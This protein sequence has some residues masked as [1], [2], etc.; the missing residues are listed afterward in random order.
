MKKLL[1]AAAI[2]CAA[3][4]SQAAVCNWSMSNVTAYPGAE[5]AAAGWK[6]YLISASE[7]DAFSALSGDKV[8]GWLAKQTPIDTTETVAGGRG[9]IN[10]GGT[11]GDNYGVGATES[12]FIVLFNNASAA[13]ATYYAYTGTKTSDPVGDGGAAI[14]LGWGDFAAETTGWKSMAGGPGPEPVPEPTSA[15]LLLL[16]VAGLA[17]RRKQ[18]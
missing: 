9:S 15:M 1:I 8:A 12:A 14:S 11:T 5:S 13:D 10:L 17:L 3:A 4:M 6:A 7:Y 18:A 16:G 2:V